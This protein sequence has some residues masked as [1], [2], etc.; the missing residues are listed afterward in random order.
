M[1][2][3]RKFPEKATGCGP[4]DNGD[5]PRT[6]QRCLPRKKDVLTGGNSEGF[7]MEFEA[8]GVHWII[9]SYFYNVG[10]KCIC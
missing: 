8:L 1:R 5:L 3:E 4:E 7:V 2:L 10:T 6:G 9:S